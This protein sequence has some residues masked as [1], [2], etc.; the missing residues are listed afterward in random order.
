MWKVSGVVIAGIATPE[1]NKPFQDVCGRELH[2]YQQFS[3]RIPTGGI[4]DAAA[5]RLSHAATPVA[6]ATHNRRCVRHATPHTDTTRLG[7][8]HI[9]G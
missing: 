4:L 8:V 6:G 2:R 5:D 1:P 7:L 9:D 3:A